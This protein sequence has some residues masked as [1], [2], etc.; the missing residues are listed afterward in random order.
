MN[1]KSLVVL[2]VFASVASVTPCA[3]P[4]ST[5]FKVIHMARY[6]EAMGR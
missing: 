5:V 1:R 2:A 4:S 6:R 3:L